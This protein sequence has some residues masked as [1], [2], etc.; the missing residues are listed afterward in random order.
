MI[1]EARLSRLS[2][3]TPGAR[4][5]RLGLAHECAEAAETASVEAGLMHADQLL[6]GFGRR[7]A[8]SARATGHRKAKSRR[9]SAAHPSTP[10]AAAS[11]GVLRYSQNV[12]TLARTRANWRWEHGSKEGSKEEDGQEVHG[13]QVDA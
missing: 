4:L 11:E 13:P 6:R 5:V 7:H 12:S 8:P 10:I 3:S 9:R 1:G 2:D